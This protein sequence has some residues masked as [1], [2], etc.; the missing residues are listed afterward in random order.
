MEEIKKSMA[1]RVS[2]MFAVSALVCVSYILI[3]PYIFKLLFPQYLA[4][5]FA[6][7]ILALAILFQPKGLIETLITAHGDIKKKY[8]TSISS[9]LIRV[10]LLAALVP[11]HGFMG[12]AIAIVISEFISSIIYFVAY[13]RL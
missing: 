4:S 2:Q 6:S 13:K 10:T 12:A 5:V 8:A 3:A 11:F 1:F 9:N 7:Q